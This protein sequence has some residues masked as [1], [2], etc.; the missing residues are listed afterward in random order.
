MKRFLGIAAIVLI[1]AFAGQGILAQNLKFG[2]INSDDLI[3]SMPDYDSA[4]VKLERSRKELVNT[5]E[6]LQVEFNNKYEAYNK[7][8]KNLTDLVKQT[9]EQELADMNKR[10]T[11]FQ[12]NAQTS[13]QE[14]QSALF[15]PIVAKAD[16]AI[17]D[18]GKEGGFTYVFDVAKGPLAYFDETKS[19]NILP[20]VKAKL[21]IK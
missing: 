18:V 4:T 10:L 19:T 13:L 1:G 17:K 8:S 16:K 7:E 12:N 20:L 14:Q 3:K 11:D 9:K 5:L 15:Q 21:G 2:H 6:I